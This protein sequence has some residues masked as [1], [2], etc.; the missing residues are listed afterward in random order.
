MGSRKAKLWAEKKI[1]EIEMELVR[2]SCQ[3]GLLWEVDAESS[4]SRRLSQQ[5]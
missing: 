1:A 3:L 4:S 2:K 5:S